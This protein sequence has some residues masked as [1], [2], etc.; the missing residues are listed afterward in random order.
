VSLG[1]L[2]VSRLAR[3]G[4]LGE[5][6]S[7]ERWPWTLLA[8][9]LPAWGFH[10]LAS[11]RSVA[12]RAGFRWLGSLGSV[13]NSVKEVA[14]LQAVELDAEKRRRYLWVTLLTVPLMVLQLF[15]VLGVTVTFVVIEV[16]LYDVVWETLPVLWQLVACVIY[17]LAF[18]IAFMLILGLFHP[19]SNFVTKW[20]G[21][22][23]R[24]LS[25]W[26]LTAKIYA[27]W[28]FAVFLY[29]FVIAFLYVPFG[30]DLAAFVE[31][32]PHSFSAGSEAH[33]AANS[34]A[35]SGEAMHRTRDVV[36]HALSEFHPDA[37]RLTT[38]VLL[39]FVLQD[40]T[41]LAQVL[42]PV[43]R[44]LWGMGR[45]H[46]RSQEHAPQRHK[47]TAVISG[48]L[49]M[50]RV[51]LASRH[52]CEDEEL[53]FPGR[54]SRV[55]DGQSET[56]VESEDLDDD[57]Y[58]LYSARS[59]ERL[60]DSTRKRSSISSS[61]VSQARSRI[62]TVS[63]RRSRISTISEARRS[64]TTS[65]A[66]PRLSLKGLP[67][68]VPATPATRRRSTHV[69]QA[70][71]PLAAGQGCLV[72]YLLVERLR[73]DRTRERR[74]A[75]AT[76]EVAM[77]ACGLEALEAAPTVTSRLRTCYA[78]ASRLGVLEEDPDEDLGDLFTL[79]C[80]G[81][82][83]KG[84]PGCGGTIHLSLLVEV[85]EPGVP[86]PSSSS[87]G[88]TNSWGSTVEL[89]LEEGGHSG[90]VESEST[91]ETLRCLGVG[92]LAAKAG[93]AELGP[94]RVQYIAGLVRAPTHAEALELV[95]RALRRARQGLP[96]EDGELA[97][98]PEEM[99]REEAR[100]LA[101]DPE[102]PQAKQPAGL[103]W[104]WWDEELAALYWEEVFELFSVKETF[105]T[106]EIYAHLATSFS[107]VC[108]FGISAPICPLLALLFT[109]VEV[110]QDQLRLLWLS[111]PPHPDE[112]T[113]RFKWRVS[114]GAWYEILRFTCHLSVVVNLLLWGL[115]YE[116]LGGKP[117]SWDAGCWWRAL[118]LLLLVERVA[119]QLSKLLH[120][121]IAQLDHETA[122][123]Y[124][125]R[126]QRLRRAFVAEDDE[127][128]SRKLGHRSSRQLK[129]EVCRRRL[130]RIP[131]KG[132]S[133]LV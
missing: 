27:N 41:R 88:G 48:L 61:H 86:P 129:R 85:L 8:L 6:P 20:E 71:P 25:R 29:F 120:Q 132:L 92:A 42:L 30:R 33:A 124:L 40:L 103:P 67:L 90:V 65:E 66:R 54:K 64:F 122:S 102:L 77:L 114:L 81:A 9:F 18:G 72:A 76:E 97:P 68:R 121:Y 32:L 37:N 26:H 89:S 22:P 21:H 131:S 15:V 56:S 78:S 73:I 127:E 13:Q 111:R 19:V 91:G 130:T 39:F 34:T 36:R 49:A 50:L 126:Y 12:S 106:F 60:V 51:C 83:S 58:I 24:D 47:R 57:E 4:L 118:A 75:E 1:C 45:F 44:A 3:S 108:L 5:T 100:A 23:D 84:P 28:F 115:T 119:V 87:E 31:G 99:A 35:R 133:S 105:E 2:A 70:L 96:L 95:P 16:Y 43:L 93:E 117:A 38:D 53:S 52:R 125:R 109:S 80:E 110:R 62:S 69:S 59:S 82:L 46:G 74:G 63:E 10:F 104:V 112:E 17:N 113:L 123:A 116:G 79:A 14:R 128:E 101:G 7:L 107:Y 94:V 98:R 11:W 55:A